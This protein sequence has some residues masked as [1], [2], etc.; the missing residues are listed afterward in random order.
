M[1]CEGVRGRLS[2]FTDGG[3]EPPLEEDTEARLE[4]GR[5]EGR[6]EAGREPSESTG[7]GSEPS[8]KTGGGSTMPSLTKGCGISLTTSL[9][10]ALFTLLLL[11]LSL[12]ALLLLLTAFLLSLLFSSWKDSGAGGRGRE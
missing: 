8:A 5:E 3:G 6:A 2:L 1:S 9:M 12:P 11:L 10:E 7:G 4:T